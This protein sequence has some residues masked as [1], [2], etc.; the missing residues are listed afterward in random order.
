MQQ[1]SR[2][3]TIIA[4][5]LPCEGGHRNRQVITRSYK[6]MVIYIRSDAQ[7]FSDRKGQLVIEAQAVA[8]GHLSKILLCPGTCLVLILSLCNPGTG[9][10]PPQ[11]HQQAVR[12]CKSTLLSS[13]EK[14]YLIRHISEG[15]RTLRG[16][17]ERCL[18]SLLLLISS[19]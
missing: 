10:P 19:G 9:C 17:T 5:R 12:V 3:L 13:N 8:W 1:Q 7:G 4:E 15:M 6:W 14:D 16:I 2:Q 18:A 11:D